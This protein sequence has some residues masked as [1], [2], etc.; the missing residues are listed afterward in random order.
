V[1]AQGAVADLLARLGNRDE[2]TRAYA[3]ANEGLARIGDRAARVSAVVLLARS[4]ADAGSAGT[5]ALLVE[6]AT[7]SAARIPDPARRAQALREIALFHSDQGNAMAA[8]LVTAT[9]DNANVRADIELALVESLLAAGRVAA[10]TEVTDV[11]TV[12]AF[13]ARALGQLAAGQHAG[14]N[15]LFRDLAPVTLRL[16]RSEAGRVQLPA[17]QAIV[18]AELARAAHAIGDAASAGSLFADAERVTAAID[19]PEVRSPVLGVL[20][21]HLA[22]AGRIDDGRRLAGSITDTTFAVTVTED[23]ARVQ[24]A[25][26]IV[27]QAEAEVTAPAPAGTAPATR[28]AAVTPAPAAPAPTPG[29]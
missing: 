25:L 13:R 10:A 17:D 21:G 5:A 2:A 14:S 22:R 8:L 11:I 27:Q 7:L 28:A 6:D 3:A 24:Q 18:L 29:R 12:P 16:A 26:Q 4:H 1:A 15:A 9:I 20:A 19:A 23:V